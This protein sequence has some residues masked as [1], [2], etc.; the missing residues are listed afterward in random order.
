M[1]QEVNHWLELTGVVILVIFLFRPR[2]KPPSHPLP[3]S[4]TA[5]LLRRLLA[6]KTRAT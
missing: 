1:S 6:H 5:L 2:R 3:S 4:D